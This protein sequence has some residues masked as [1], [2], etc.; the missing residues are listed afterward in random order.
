MLADRIFGGGSC[1]TTSKPSMT[2]LSRC[3]CDV[4]R[5]CHDA[6]LDRP[7][8][9]PFSDLLTDDHL[10]RP[11][12]ATLAGRVIARP[13]QPEPFRHL[14][15]LWLESSS[16]ASH[17]TKATV[18]PIWRSNRASAHS[19]ATSSY[20][21]GFFTVSIPAT[22][23]PPLTARAPER[24]DPREGAHPACLLVDHNLCYRYTRVPRLRSRQPVG[25]SVR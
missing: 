3:Q 5:N 4:S 14:D 17:F 20:T 16:L 8:R 24:T 19:I 15:V 18:G 21:N 13:T 9:R 22:G 12:P 23:A 7:R 11:P 2:A 10:D 25:P 6:R 1:G